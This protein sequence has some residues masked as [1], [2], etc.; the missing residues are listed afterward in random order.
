MAQAHTGKTI[1]AFLNDLLFETKIRSTG[2][3]IGADLRIVRSIAELR[4]ALAAAPAMLIIDL[5]NCGG[6]DAEAITLAKSTTPAPRVI[7]YVSHVDHD[8]AQRASLAGA[9]EVMPRSRFTT[10]LPH[11]LQSA[12]E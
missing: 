6:Q 7:A 1:I 10:V 2:Q 8:L 9:D 5:N 11:L 4:S 3:A 12:T